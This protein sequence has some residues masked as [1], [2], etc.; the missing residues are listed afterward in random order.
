V[1]EQ[2]LVLLASLDF[3]ISIILS[4]KSLYRTSVLSLIG[5]RPLANITRTYNDTNTVLVTAFIIVER[6]D[7]YLQYMLDNFKKDKLIHVA[8]IV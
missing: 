4:W 6:G 1:E 2:D 3:I 8:R 7:A 5:P